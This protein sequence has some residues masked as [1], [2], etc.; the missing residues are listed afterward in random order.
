MGFWSGFLSVTLP[1]P[2]CLCKKSPGEGTKNK[3]R[4]F[5]ALGLELAGEQSRP[6]NK[7]YLRHLAAVRQVGCRTDF[8]RKL[9]VCGVGLS[10]KSRRIRE[11]RLP[12]HPFPHNLLEAPGTFGYLARKNCLL[13]HGTEKLCK[14]FFEFWSSFFSCSSTFLR[15]VFLHFFCLVKQKYLL[16][17][18]KY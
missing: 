6:S 2:I 12:S 4:K 9:G 8:H 1:S 11:D 5:W 7:L 14:T 16:N 15:P 10:Q 17:K 3:E 18:T 13:R